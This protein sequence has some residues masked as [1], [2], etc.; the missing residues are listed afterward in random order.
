M[1]RFFLCKD[2]IELIN[3]KR[4]EIMEIISN[5][6]E[7]SSKAIIAEGFVKFPGYD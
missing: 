7:R 2:I 6:E 3:E 4:R 5:I 1:L